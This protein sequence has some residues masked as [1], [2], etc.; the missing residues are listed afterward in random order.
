MVSITLTSLDRSIPDRERF[1][2]ALRDRFLSPNIPWGHFS[3]RKNVHV[4]AF[5]LTSSCQSE[6]PAV[7]EAFLALSRYI[8]YNENWFSSPGAYFT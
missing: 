5:M 4:F 7:T 2:Q 3:H 8:G 6:N 1:P